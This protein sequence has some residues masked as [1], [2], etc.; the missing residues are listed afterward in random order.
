[1]C[2]RDSQSVVGPPIFFKRG[3]GCHVT[4]EDDNTFV[5][6]CCSWG[7]LILGHNNASIREAVIE[8]A[9]NGIS[10]GVP[11]KRGN[12]LAKLILDNNRFIEKIRFVSSGT[13]AV[14]SAI[15]LARGAVSYTH[16]T[17]PTSDLV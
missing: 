7:P 15:R 3:N 17:L 8:A 1:M 14:M 4:D 10:F 6:F 11:T 16:L 12:A 5:D 2:I 9:E 13:E